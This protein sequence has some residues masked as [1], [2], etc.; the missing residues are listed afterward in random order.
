M[1]QTSIEEVRGTAPRTSS[2]VVSGPDFRFWDLFHACV[3]IVAV[4]A[5]LGTSAGSSRV[6]AVGV[7]LVLGAAYALWGR[8][9]VLSRDERTGPGLLY[10]ALTVAL[11]VVA[12]VFADASTW[13]VASLSVQAYMI[14]RWPIAVVSVAVVNLVGPAVEYRGSGRIE[15]SGL[16]IAAAITAGSAVMSAWVDR[17]ARESNERAIL[18]AELD[19]SR[20][21]VARLSRDAGTRTERAR[22]AAEIHDTLAQGYT[23]VLALIQ[24]AEASDDRDKAATHLA[25]AADACRENL[26]EARAMVAELSPAPLDDDGLAEALRRVGRRASAETGVVCDVEIVEPLPPLSRPTEVALLRVTQEA[27]TNVRKHASASAISVRVDVDAEFVSLVVS[28]D[29]VGIDGTATPENFGVRGMRSRVEQLGGTLSI[30]PGR[31]S[32]TVL[33]VEVPL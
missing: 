8:R 22:L 17:I 5:A 27:L 14:V 33:T 10:L 32:G 11:L 19:A 31:E 7:L 23:S 13:F 2:L 6:G 20:A 12:A 18:I 24:A 29:G 9:L 21:E 25:V 28:D 3:L 15:V 4:V 30:G 26:K 1:T 16:W